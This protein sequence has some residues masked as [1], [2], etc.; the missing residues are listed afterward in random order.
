MNPEKTFPSVESETS[1]FSTFMLQVLLYGMLLL[2]FGF[3]I[4]L[5]AYGIYKRGIEVM[6]F[7]VLICF[8]VG[9]GI[10]IPSVKE[11]VIKRNRVSNKII[12]DETGILYCNS[13]RE[14]VNK[15]LYTDLISS[16]ADFDVFSVNTRTSGI[17][18]MLEIFT[19][20]AKDGTLTPLL[21]Q[22]NLPLHVVKDRYSLYAHL[23]HGISIFRPDLKIAP[24]VFQNY[25]IDPK[26][27]Q[28]NRKSARYLFLI[29][30]L[31]ALLTCGL[32]LWL[33][34]YFNPSV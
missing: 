23:L 30:I 10:L 25:F 17:M 32:I 15:I 29:I 31:A 28:V 22:M 16:G 27:W 12:I 14:I 6:F 4:L 19:A 5:P 1:L 13:K 9:F 33:V 18:P 11:Y 2:C 7:P 8:P 34:F 20:S 26:T 24:Q 21:I 3:L